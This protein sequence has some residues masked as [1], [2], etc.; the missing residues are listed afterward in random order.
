MVVVALAMLGRL[1]HPLPERRSPTTCRASSSTRPKSLGGHRRRAKS[2]IADLR[3]GNRARRSASKVTRRRRRQTDAAEARLD[4]AATTRPAPEFTDTQHW[5]NTPGDKPLTMQRPARPG[6]PDRLLDLHLHQLHPHAALPERLG[7]ALPQGR[8]GDRRRPHAR[9]PLRARRRQRR[10]SDQDRTAS[11]T[12]SS[13]TTNTATW[14]AYGNQYWPAEYFVDAKGDV[15]YAHFGEGEYGEKE[16]VIREL[17]AEAGNAPGKA[18]RRRATA[19]APPNDRDDA[20]DLPRRRAGPRRFTN[21]R[22]LPGTPRLQRAPGARRKRT[23]L[24]RRVEDR[25]SAGDRGRAAQL[26]LNFGARR[27]YLVLGSPGQ[28]PRRAG[29]ARRQADRRRRSTA[30]TST[31]LRHG[32][33]TNA[34]TTWSTLPQVEHHVLELVPEDGVQ[35]YAFTFG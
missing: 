35:G 11:S 25:R 15:R 2:A 17:L 8:P 28:A 18:T 22:S 9:V 6:R 21:G 19:M 14:N 29:P 26:D 13:R 34:S 16:E 7:Q 10:G 33:P 3:G 5:F 24:R 1:R 4:A 23:L 12:R 27:V 20:G 30:P 32:R 31:R